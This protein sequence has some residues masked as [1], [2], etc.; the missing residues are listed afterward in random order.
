MK[1]LK[2]QAIQFG[3][4]EIL[5]RAQLKNVM[6]GVDDGGSGAVCLGSCPSSTASC[7]T[8]YYGGVATCL[9]SGQETKSCS[10]S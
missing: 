7:V 4:Q 8:Q 1:K 9:C 6:G 2:L 5:S 10:V 3:A